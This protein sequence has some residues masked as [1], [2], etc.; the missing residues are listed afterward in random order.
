MRKTEEREERQPGVRFVM[1]G[2]SRDKG[3]GLIGM[4]CSQDR[5]LGIHTVT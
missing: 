5:R 2:V 4:T 1:F 3:Q